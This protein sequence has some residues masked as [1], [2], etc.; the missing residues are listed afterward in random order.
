M[1][2]KDLFDIMENIFTNTFI[3]L[4]GNV[5]NF[6]ESLSCS[7]QFFIH[8]QEIPNAGIF[9]WIF[10]HKEDYVFNLNSSCSA[11]LTGF[12]C[13]FSN[14]LDHEIWRH[15]MYELLLVVTLL[16]LWEFSIE[17]KITFEQIHRFSIRILIIAKSKHHATQFLTEKSLSSLRWICFLFNFFVLFKLKINLNYLIL[18]KADY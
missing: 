4:I 15:E 7:F 5:F 12:V 13:D 11:N 17:L 1:S 16:D 6:V 14:K 2:L 8:G 9:S 18:M 10:S 3:K